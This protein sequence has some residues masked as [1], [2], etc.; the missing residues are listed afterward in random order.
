MNANWQTHLEGKGARF[1]E[2]S[3]GFHEDERLDVVAAEKGTVLVPLC[4]LG[5]IR[6]TG[7]DAAAFLHNLFSNDVKKLGPNEAQLTSFNSPKGRMLASIL[8]WREG[9]DY[10]LTLSADIH[11]AMLKK[12]SMYVL[13]SKVRLMDDSTDSVLI[14]LAG[15]QAGAALEAAGLHIPGAVK[16]TASGVATVVRLEGARFIVS[17]PLSEAAGLWDIFAAAGAVPAGSA[18]WRW[19]DITQGQPSVTLPV[20]EEF[21][22]QMLNYELIGGVSFNKGCYPG[23][24][25]VARTHYLGKLKKRMYRVHG[26]VDAP[27]APGTD[28][29]AAE[30]GEQS[31]GKVVMAAPA[32]A[33]GVD[34]LVVLQTASAEAGSVHLDSPDGVPL[35]FLPLP[36]ALG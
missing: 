28:V 34:A 9:N 15:P 1:S 14:G 20:Q 24:E 16:A 36:Y 10:L 8:L 31:A 32:P 29:Y 5:A 22:A 3:V 30:F 21:V 2:F 6:A 27:P 19:L 18:A 33:G 17:A 35:S 4:Q 13:R 11:A 12:L 25:I 7:E 23:Q 26:D